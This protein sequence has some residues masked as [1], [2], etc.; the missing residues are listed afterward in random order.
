MRQ[1]E[2]RKSPYPVLTPFVTLALLGIGIY[3]LLVGATAFD[4]ATGMM[5]VIASL[6]MVVPT[7]LM[8]PRDTRRFIRH[9]RVRAA[10][11]S[12]PL[13]LDQLVAVP[14]GSSPGELEPALSE[15]VLEAAVNG[16]VVKDPVAAPILERSWKKN[17]EYR[18]ELIA[19]GWMFGLI[20]ASWLIGFVWGVVIFM[21]A[22]CM[23][24]LKRNLPNLWHRLLFTVVSTAVMWAVTYE[25]LNL[26]H[27]TLTPLL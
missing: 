12:A 17:G 22:Y 19:I 23:I 27:V 4:L 18:R 15:S 21:V 3:A 16:E 10:Q 13:P 7:A 8:L 9:L 14:A 1:V 2:D 5:P 6:F 11:A 25:M 26:M 20:I 24:S